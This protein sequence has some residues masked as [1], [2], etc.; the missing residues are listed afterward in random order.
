LKPNKVFY[1]IVRETSKY[2]KYIKWF[3]RTY[4]DDMKLLSS[5]GYRTRREAE[6]HMA[7]MIEIGKEGFPIGDHLAYYEYTCIGA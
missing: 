7:S 5:C 6:K 1:E 2:N 3:L 4:H